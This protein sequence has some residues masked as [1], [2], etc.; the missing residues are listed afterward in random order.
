MQIITYKTKHAVIRVSLT[1]RNICFITF[2]KLLS[3]LTL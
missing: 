3:Q 2:E 1:Y